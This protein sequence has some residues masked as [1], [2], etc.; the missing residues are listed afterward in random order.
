MSAPAAV[1]AEEAGELA[2]LHATAFAHPWNAEAI[3]EVLAGPGAFGLRADGGFILARTLAGEAEI[4]TLAVA[5]LARRRGLAKR[6]VEAAIVQSLA[7][8]ADSLFLEVA[9]DNAPAIALYVGAGFET[10]GRRRGYYASPGGGA[11]QDALVMRLT[12]NS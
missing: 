9:A 4:L 7:A 11:A 10:V 1:S 12:L 8:G 3:A 5:P 6:L 2:V